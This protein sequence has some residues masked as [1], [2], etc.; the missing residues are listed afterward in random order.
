[1]KRTIL[2]VLY[3]LIFP[4]VFA[5]SFF[6]AIS[7]FTATRWVCFAGIMLSYA[8]LVMT[9]CSFPKAKGGVVYGYPKTTVGLSFFIVE[10]L[11]GL[12]FILINNDSY[13]FPMVV[14]AIIVGLYLSTYIILMVTED[15]SIESDRIDAK[16]IFFVKN[17]SYSL[18]ETMRK[19]S[20]REQIKMVESLYDAVRNSQVKT[21][22][23]VYEE[24]C[25]L[26]DIVNELCAVALTG[27]KEKI[28]QLVAQGISILNSRNN[29]IKLS[30]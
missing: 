30:R 29:K 24:E 2:V 20:D 12:L 1:M 17:A 10:F 11:V 14:Q 15:H 21:I 16:N 6:F 27:D 23:A 9:F 3:F 25:R 13:V 18:E 7:N 28:T 8:F 22:A 5:V 19:M 4:I 26:M